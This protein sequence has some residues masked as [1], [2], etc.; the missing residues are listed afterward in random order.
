MSEKAVAIGSNPEL[1]PAAPSGLETKKLMQYDANKKSVLI[2]YLLWFFFG[3][4]GGHRFYLGKSG[5]A[6]ALLLLTLTGAITSW[7]FI[8]FLILLVPAIW[9]TV[10]A[11][12]IPGMVRDTNNNLIQMLA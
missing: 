7:F 9:L 1:I 4:L 12:L 3:W 2:S 10:D 8:G 6:I 5:S 11:F